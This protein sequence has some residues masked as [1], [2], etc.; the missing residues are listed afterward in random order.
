MASWKPL[1]IEIVDAARH[2]VEPFVPGAVGAA[3]GQ[4]WEPGL[5]W[6]DRL[7]QWT[8]G[9]T[10]AAFLIPAAGDVFHWPLPLINAVGFV[11]GTLAFRPT[12]PCARPPSSARP[13][14]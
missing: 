9:V 8:V 14:G 10:F 3:I 2:W 7:A 1:I 4:M 13:V 5:G 11:V 12:S 6:R